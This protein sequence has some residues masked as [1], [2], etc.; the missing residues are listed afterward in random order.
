ME[1]AIVIFCVVAALLAM[2]VY[3]KRGM[4]GRIRLSADSLGQQ[5]AP[6]NTTGNSTLR[7]TSSSR[8]TSET[9]TERQLTQKYYGYPTNVTTN[10]TV[11]CMDVDGDGIN[12][13]YDLDGDGILENDEFAT[14]RMSVLNN[15][16]TQQRGDE[17]IG[18]LESS[19]FD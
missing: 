13:C 6:R 10:A 7:Y 1:Y 11:Y 12:D 8:E 19:L 15:A 14:E 4:Q 18:P 5:Y 17:N 2:Q 3:L 9:L 16:T